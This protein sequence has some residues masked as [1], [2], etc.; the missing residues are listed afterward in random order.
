MVL[1]NDRIKFSHYE[2]QKHAAAMKDLHAIKKMREVILE[3]QQSPTPAT[4]SN[5]KFTALLGMIG[6]DTS[7]CECRP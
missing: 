1:I 3:S 5:T 2:L 4:I 6:F 7:V